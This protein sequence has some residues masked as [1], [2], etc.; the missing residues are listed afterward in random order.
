MVGGFADECF[1]VLGFR[2]AFYHL[3]KLL[4]L[5][6]VRDMENSWFE[7]EYGETSGVPSIRDCKSI[8]FYEFDK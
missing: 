6:V 7:D 5:F 1:Q 2:I 8:R 4:L 3:L